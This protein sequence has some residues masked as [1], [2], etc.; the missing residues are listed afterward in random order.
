MSIPATSS[1]N[2]NFPY[3]REENHDLFDFQSSETDYS[4][5]TKDH[6]ELSH[7][8]EPDQHP[9]SAI[10]GLQQRLSVI[11]GNLGGIPYS[12]VSRW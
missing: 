12:V 4:F 6:R 9:I 10:T 1:G 8:D 7:R 2:H 11:E 5:S 3:E